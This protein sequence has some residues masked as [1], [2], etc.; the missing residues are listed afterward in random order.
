MVSLI[1][2]SW[3]SKFSKIGVVRFVTC[4]VTALTINAM[5]PFPAGGLRFSIRLQHFSAFCRL[6]RYPRIALSGHPDLQCGKGLNWVLSHR[7][8]R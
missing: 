5:K 3:F 4:C 7:C 8:L 2:S 6:A 1:S